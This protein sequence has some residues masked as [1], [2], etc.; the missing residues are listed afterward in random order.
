MYH[1]FTENI[2]SEQ[3]VITGADVNHI[4]NV[5][6]MKPGDEMLVSDG[7]GMDA[8]CRISLI[9]DEEVVADVISRADDRELPVRLTLY[10]ALPK[11]DKMETIIQK[12]TELGVSRIVPVESSRCVVKL[13]SKTKVKK[14]ERWQKIAQSASEQSQRGCIPEISDVMCFKDVVQEAKMHGINVFAYERADDRESLKKLLAACR[15]AGEEAGK[16]SGLE[17]GIF[18]G[19]EGG[20]SEEEADMARE[21]GISWITLGQRILR[22]ETAGMA[23][24]AAVMLEIEAGL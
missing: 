1:C 22:T 21:A 18:V 6:R 16:C 20:W 4:R 9:T 17:I 13:D 8:V 2:S 3:A 5:L 7:R 10:Q 11:G 14:V 19:P 15:E 23:V 24:I 12:C